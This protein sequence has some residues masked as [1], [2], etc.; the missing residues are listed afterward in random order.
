M[1]A[2]IINM[3]ISFVVQPLCS[4]ASMCLIFC[5]LS[6]RRRPTKF[7]RRR[8]D[9]NKRATGMG[10][11]SQTPPERG[12]NHVPTHVQQTGRPHRRRGHECDVHN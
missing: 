12:D 2:L 11:S 1:Y 7:H 10:S 8:P 3:W 5:Y 9:R 4:V 6:T